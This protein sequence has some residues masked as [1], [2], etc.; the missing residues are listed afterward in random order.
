[1]EHHPVLPTHRSFSHGETD[2]SN[3]LMQMFNDFPLQNIG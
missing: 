2:F 1:M 3:L